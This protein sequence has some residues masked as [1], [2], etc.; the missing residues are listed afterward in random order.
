MST[1]LGEATPVHYMKP[2]PAP[3]L[4]W[5]LCAADEDETGF[6]CGAEVAMLSQFAGEREVLFPPLAML[7]VLPRASAAA[8]APGAA[9]A[10]PA[11]M[12]PPMVAAADQASRAPAMELVS[13]SRAALQVT[14]EKVR[15]DAGVEKEF[16]RIV[17]LPTFTG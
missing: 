12:P 4:L 16:E 6:H 5:Q 1:S 13:R 11:S 14:C 15:D 8:A 3:N 9:A 7:R 17:V 2:A 10:N